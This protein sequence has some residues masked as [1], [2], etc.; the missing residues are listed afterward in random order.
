MSPINYRLELPI[1][2]RIHP[3]FHVDLLT[4]YNETPMHGTNYQR[5]PPELIDGEEEYEVE[6]VIASR[7]FGRGRKLQYLVKWKGYPDS[8]NQW[9][10]KEDIFADEADR[11]SVV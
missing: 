3:V 5:P 11:K 1:Q 10:S 9:V 7:H 8:D 2:W 4:R 6:K